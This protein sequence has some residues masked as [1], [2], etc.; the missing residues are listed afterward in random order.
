MAD[1]LS[2][3]LRGGV[4]HVVGA[5]MA[6]LSA[7]L[8]LAEAGRRVVVWESAGHAGGR[9]RSFHDAALDRLIDNGS[10][11][12]LTGN[13]GV[14]RFL[15]RAGSSDGLVAAA[16]A[17]FPMVDL[18]AQGPGQRFTIR[19]DPGRLQRW[20]FDPARRIPGTGPLDLL[21]G[22][23]LALARPGTTVAEAI[24]DRGPAWRGFWEPLTLGILNTTPEKG[25]AQLLWRVMAE[26]FLKGAGPSRPMFAPAGLGAALVEPAVR[27]LIRHGVDLRLNTRIK[28]IERADGRAIAIA[29]GQETVAIG[30]E[31]S[32]IIAL[33]PSRLTRLMPEIDAPA[34]DAAILNAHFR[35]AD[36]AALEHAAPLTGLLGTLGQWIFVREDVVSVTVSAA[37]ETG[38]LDLPRGETAARL[39]REVAAALRL[40]GEPVASRIIVEKRATFDQSPSGVA[41]RP[42]LVTSMA[43]VHLAG[44]ATQTGLPATIEGA[45]R[46]GEAAASVVLSRDGKCDAKRRVTT[47]RA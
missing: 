39:W 33:P 31:D 40:E 32:V 20:I 12:I 24:R 36:R 44:D 46:S 7:A 38:I 26:T 14:Q 16:E 18:A 9:V 28:G 43:N 4:T 41:R 45:M 8:C 5:G 21:G 30:A 25:A 15:A 6:G 42:A 34:D 10:H 37:H 35:V 19:L 23:R 1:G 3:E 2:P 22:W 13:H 11:L 29:T 27:T 47:A 17:S